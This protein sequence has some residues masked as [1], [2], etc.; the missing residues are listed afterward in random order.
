MPATK[1]SIPS[2]TPP[3]PKVS[4]NQEILE[5]ARDR[6]AN[7]PTDLPGVRRFDEHPAEWDKQEQAPQKPAQA[8]GAPGLST[9]TVAGLKQVLKANA[10]QA[11]PED[12]Q[13]D[14]L[15]DAP[16]PVPPPVQTDDQKMRATIE[17][18][19]TELDIGQY[20][21]SGGEM[22]QKVPIIPGKLEVVYRLSTDGEDVF[23]DYKMR[24][25][26]DSTKGG[27]SD[28]ETYRRL[29]EWALATHVVSIN[30][31]VW[32]PTIGGTGLV[33]EKAMSNRLA[34][35]R[36]LPSQIV[37]MLSQNL[38]WFVDRTAKSLNFEA[39][40]NG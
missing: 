22:T 19:L 25:E 34:K 30:G 15:D 27:W 8:Q 33:D 14:V 21:L 28:R 17:A 23:V 12:Q 5:R 26:N 16:V 6:A 35:V 2:V 40:K 31:Q 1:P 9:Q 10:T 39:L 18:R 20:L 24:E 38:A 32:G 7:K 3:P 4:R 13:E 36:K 29:T 37:I 11:T